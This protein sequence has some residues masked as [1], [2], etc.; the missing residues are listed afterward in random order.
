M[1]DKFALSDSCGYIYP[2]TLTNNGRQLPSVIRQEERSEAASRTADFAHPFRV[3]LRA[4]VPIHLGA[5]VRSAGDKSRAFGSSFAGGEGQGLAFL[6]APS[7]RFALSFVFPPGAA[8]AVRL[9]D[10]GSCPG[11]GL[12]AVA[13]VRLG[14]APS[15]ASI[16]ATRVRFDLEPA[17]AFVANAAAFAFALVGRG[18]GSRVAWLARG[19]LMAAGAVDPDVPLPAGTPSAF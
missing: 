19:L 8:A 18:A 9:V 14:A 12:G 3:V 6:F 4:L 5:R 10:R 2:T 17:G 1:S 16:G 7:F 15:A 11:R 13:F